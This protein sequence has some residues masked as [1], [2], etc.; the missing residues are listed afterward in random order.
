MVV[1]H[2]PNSGTRCRGA[3]HHNNS[4]VTSRQIGQRPGSGASAPESL[5]A[6]A[7]DPGLMVGV[8]RVP[9]SEVILDQAEIVTAVG[10]VEAARVASICGWT[11]GSS[12]RSAAV[13]MR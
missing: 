13:A 4:R 2:S 3:V 1:V 12:A 7:R 9:V 11:G 5:E 10:E 8:L 6:T